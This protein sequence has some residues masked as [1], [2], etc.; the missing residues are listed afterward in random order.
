MCE[1][2]VVSVDE[3]AGLVAAGVELDAVAARDGDEAGGFLDRGGN[4]RVAVAPDE[5]VEV[6]VRG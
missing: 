3:E 5:S 4:V 6:G 2:G 1:A